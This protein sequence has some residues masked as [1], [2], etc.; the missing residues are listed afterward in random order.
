MDYS[1]LSDKQLLALKNKDYSTLSDDELLDLKTKQNSSVPS[2]KKIPFLHSEMSISDE[3]SETPFAAGL[4]RGLAIPEMK[5]L[6]GTISKTPEI[7]SSDDKW[8]SLKKEYSKLREDELSRLKETG[9]DSSGYTAG[10]AIGSLLLPIPG[11][12][13]TKG[14]SKVAKYIPG[15]ERA[16][17]TLISASPKLA[18]VADVAATTGAT[19]AI[20]GGIYGE[21]DIESNIATGGIL[22]SA[23]GTGI[24]LSP[25]LVA[26]PLAAYSAYQ[27]GHGGLPGI[28]AAAAAATGAYLAPKA[29]S[30]GKKGIP[31]GEE[32]NKAM[33]QQLAKEMSED[34]FQTIFGEKG[35]I[36]SAMDKQSLARTNIQNVSEEIDV[37]V[38]LSDYLRS[39]SVPHS[40]KSKLSPIISDETPLVTSV[41][42]DTVQKLAEKGE[43][44]VLRGKAEG[45]NI[46]YNV[47]KDDKGNVI[48]QTFEHTPGGGE[49][50]I[51]K[52]VV[53]ESQVPTTKSKGAFDFSKRENAEARLRQ[54]Q[55]KAEVE[56][57]GLTYEL[58]EDPTNRM[59]HVVEK[60][61]KVVKSK[62]PTQEFIPGDEPLINNLQTIIK[63][64]EPGV[65]T[66]ENID[67]MK[68]RIEASKLLDIRSKVSDMLS[69]KRYSPNDEISLSN[70]L[71]EVDDQIS[72]IDPKYKEATKELHNIFQ[73]Q[74]HELGS[75]YLYGEV[76]NSSSRDVLK[77]K[78][79]EKLEKLFADASPQK[80]EAIIER[81]SEGNPDIKL[82]LKSL[83]DRLSET[84]KAADIPFSR[85]L[86]P[87]AKA[88]QK[89]TDIESSLSKSMDKVPESLRP[90]VRTGSDYIKNLLS[91]PGLT[92]GVSGPAIQEDI[93]PPALRN[94]KEEPKQTPSKDH[95]RNLYNMNNDDLVATLDSASQNAPQL[96]SSIEQ[97]KQAIQDGDM[98]RK[99]RLLFSLVQNPIFRKETSSEG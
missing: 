30:A 10:E 13:V 17:N 60:G 73:I 28:G 5:A 65:E 4:E 79:L 37:P 18:K 8:E 78:S 49:R 59:F 57:S 11:G 87:I 39:E 26:P 25:K 70:I 81:V 29:F 7:L 64:Y 93:I 68:S 90:A 24:Q 33:Q 67:M 62:V 46:G 15:V 82:K 56:G 34:T 91:V 2:Q 32:E 40:V 80:A 66:V 95:S 41:S 14:V 23:I 20:Q 42:Q 50:I 92:K 38:S 58:T 53:S 6:A 55:S 21:G 99:D 48:L 61:S 35:R 63:K 47:N 19:G 3:E 44:A 12:T 77:I 51:D 1:K 88:G 36:P 75:P 86:A 83:Y 76:T 43:L 85:Q 27:L 45:R 16:V 72:K 74:K 89:L 22:G 52:S 94:N 97:L 69:S 98:K 84:R 71:N 9:R 31:L 96:N 54:L